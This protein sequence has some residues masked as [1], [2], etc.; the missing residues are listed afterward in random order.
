MNE[1]P[2]RIAAILLLCVMA[3]ASC[4]Q[5]NSSLEGRVEKLEQEAQ[6][7]TPV[8]RSPAG[9]ACEKTSDCEDGLA[10]KRV[11]GRS[12]N[13]GGTSFS[14]P[15]DRECTIVPTAVH[16]NDLTQGNAG[17]QC[18][19]NQDCADALICWARTCVKKHNTGDKCYADDDC[20]EGFC[21]QSMCSKGEKG[22]SCDGDR[23]CISANCSYPG[24]RCE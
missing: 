14:T 12:H 2:Y 10:C 17:D 4:Q 7:S 23:D 3:Q 22:H 21:A 9:F 15:S 20:V 11:V 18:Q 5:D 1:K 8:R 6:K 13:I 24:R 19:K 16:S